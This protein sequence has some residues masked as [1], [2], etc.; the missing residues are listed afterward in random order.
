[1]DSVLVDSTS[2]AVLAY[3]IAFSQ[4]PVMKVTAVGTA[5]GVPKFIGAFLDFEPKFVSV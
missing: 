3:Q 1:L 5:I 4:K 2:D